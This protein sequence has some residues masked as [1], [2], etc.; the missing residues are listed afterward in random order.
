MTSLSELTPLGLMTS[1]NESKA[2]AMQTDNEADDP[3][4][5]PKGNWESTSIDRPCSLEKRNR[6]MNIENTVILTL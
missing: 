5:A 1:K 2:A 3:K 6:R 4:P